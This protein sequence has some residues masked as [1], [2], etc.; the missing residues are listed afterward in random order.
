MAG[1][2]YDVHYHADSYVDVDF[3]FCR[4]W[5]GDGGCYGTNPNHGFSFE[6]AKRHIIQHYKKYMQYWEEM[7]E[8]TWLSRFSSSDD[9]DL[10]PP[11]SPPP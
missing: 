9:E 11:D 7:T 5:D 4:E 1:N 3:H 2:K 10:S 8:E 6:D